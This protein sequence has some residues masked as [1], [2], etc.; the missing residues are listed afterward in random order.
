MVPEGRD[1]FPHRKEML[2]TVVGHFEPC[3]DLP[4]AGQVGAQ[5]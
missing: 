3:D 1:R 4:P 5:R 2:P